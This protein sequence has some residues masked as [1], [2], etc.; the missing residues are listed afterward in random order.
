VQRRPAV[1]VCFA[2][3]L[4]LLFLAACDLLAGDVTPEAAPTPTSPAQ[5]I[6]EPTPDLSLTPIAVETPPA[7]QSMTLTLWTRPDVV[8]SSE[9]P[10]SAALLEQLTT[11]DAQHEELTLLVEAKA[12]S[13]QG[14]A[15]SYLR[16]GRTVAPS[17]LPDLLLLPAGQLADAVVE[18]LVFPLDGALNEEMVGALFPAARAL[19]Q[20][21][22][23]TYGYPYALTNVQHLVYDTAVITRT[24]PVT[25]PELQGANNDFRLIFPA[26]S[27]DGARMTL[28]LYLAAGGALRNSAGQLALEPEPL[29]VALGQI[30]QATANGRILPESIAAT[31]LDQAWQLFQN[32]TANVLLSDAMTYQRQRPPAGRY[33]FAPLPGLEAALPLRAGALLWVVTTPDPVRQALAVELIAWLAAPENLA[34]WSYAANFVPARADALALWPAGDAHAAFLARMLPD[35]RPHPAEA[36]AALLSALAQ[37]TENVTAGAQTAANAAEA[38]ATALIP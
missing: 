31:S 5:T 6:P 28:E 34:R 26:A 18:N 10:G 29:T 38:A 23:V 8:P 21:D 14:G 32:S 9:E 1:T 27:Q 33:A 30:Q 12:S 36:S 24:L 37:A 22:G 7:Q 11:F 2:L 17:I 20:V 35:A 15:L 4:P 3:I 25:W 16:T 19:A 13:G